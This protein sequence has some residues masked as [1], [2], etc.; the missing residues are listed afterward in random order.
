MSVSAR[1]TTDG[2]SAPAGRTPTGRMNRGRARRTSHHPAMGRR[3]HGG[4][5]S[6]LADDEHRPGRRAGRR[7]GDGPRHVR[8]LALPS[9][10]ARP[11]PGDRAGHGA[12]LPARGRGAGRAGATR[13]FL[14]D[15]TPSRPRGGPARS[16]R[17][18]RG[19]PRARRAPGPPAARRRPAPRGVLRQAAWRL[20]ATGLGGALLGGAQFGRGRS[21]TVCGWA[22]ASP[23]SRWRS[24]SASA[25][26]TSWTGSAPA[27]PR[28][29][30]AAGRRPRAAVP[31]R[32]DRDRSAASPASPT[33]STRSPT[34]PRRRL[35]AALPGAPSSGGWPATPASSPGWGS[36]P[37]RSGTGRCGGSRP[38]RRPTCPC[39]SRARTSRWVPP[40][41]SGGPGSLVP[42]AGLG[43]DGRLHALA[44]V[45][46]RAVPIRPDGVPDLSIE[47][48][49]G[50]PARAAPVQVYVGLDSAADPARAGRPGDGRDWSGP[51]P[52]TGRCSSS[53]RRPAPATSTTSP[54]PRCSTCTRGDVA[55]VTLQ[56]SRRPVA[57]VPGHG[58]GRPRAE[59]A[60]VAAD[61]GAPPR[62]ARSAAPRRAVRRE[63]RRAHQPGRLPALGHAGPRRDGHRPGAVD[64]DAVR[65]QVDAPGHPRRPPRRR[66]GRPSPW[67]T[68]SPSSSRW[69]S[70]AA[71][72]RASSCSATTTTA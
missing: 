11:G 66:P 17:L 68:T 44:S 54:S 31:R 50:E 43:R 40:T 52:S 13:R 27:R 14:A 16:R 7:R 59:P 39:S 55:T 5:A 42:W 38:G 47:T 30:D 63:P 26:P 34:S 18:R 71:A 33:A 56:Y 10:R 45:R 9:E 46:P 6:A 70:S 3:R 19:A 69:P 36:A 35:A 57:A 67:S 22:D 29:P 24:R 23:P 60:A 12:A 21:T 25:S 53:S 49:M 32:R 62:A 65:Q 64:R 1:R 15:G 58:R 41:V 48:V 4:A 37:P 20:G 2:R 51:A 28:T 72:R 8:A 61:P